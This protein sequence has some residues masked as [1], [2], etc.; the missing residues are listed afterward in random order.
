[1]PTELYLD[2]ARLGLISPTAKS[3]SEAYLRIAERESAS[4][5]FDSMLFAD[6]TTGEVGDEFTTWSGIADLKE[7]FRRFSGMTATSSVLLAGR[8]KTFARIAARL[9]FGPCRNLLVTDLGW[10]DYID[11]L[12]SHAR[13]LG[14]KVDRVALV[15]PVLRDRATPSDM[16]NLIVEAYRRGNCDGLFLSAVSNT[17]INVDV[18][19]II[20]QL[21]NKFD[22]PIVVV[23]GAQHLA[24]LPA[25]LAD[26]CDFYFASTHKWL[27]SHLPLAVACYGQ[28]R[29]QTWIDA[30]VRRLIDYDEIDD[31]LLRLVE[32]CRSDAGQF[33]ETVN[34]AP[35]F[36]ASG[37]LADA[38]NADELAMSSQRTNVDI[39]GEL[40][41]DCGWQPLLPNDHFRS[42]IL[43]AESNRLRGA[44]PSI[45]RNGLQQCGLAATTYENGLVRLSAPKKL[46]TPTDLDIVRHAFQSC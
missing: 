42:G 23:D 9:F 32:E 1:M 16:L 39:L 29:S 4:S 8:T 14:R 13:R 15:D 36:A 27:G 44:K 45:L 22:L 28:S 33:G 31:P 41:A 21:E 46:L 30:T 40:L 38:E 34:L 3:E 6:D 18:C 43:L 26:C 12:N 35:L 5:R 7:R 2:T 20:A 17:G 24:H 11:I 10:P 25:R 19:A 37:A